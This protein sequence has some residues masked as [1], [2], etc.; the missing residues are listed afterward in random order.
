MSELHRIFIAAEL[1]P[2]LQQSIVETERQLEEAGAKLRWTKPANLHFTLRFLGEI[3]L[4]QVA[5]AKLATRE[6]AAAIQPFS[7]TLATL[8]AFPSLQRPQVVWVG[9][10]EG[11]ESL[12]T[13]A[14]RLDEQ[15][16]RYRFPRERRQFQPHLTLA[17]IR[18]ARAWGDLV[19]GL[20]QF[21][22]VSVGTQQIETL[23]VME[24]QLTPQGSSYTRVEE[25]RLGTYEK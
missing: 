3:P 16:V 5:K 19:R 14:A 13:L 2:A 23:V 18:D 20:T 4:A 17:R 10:A 7:I 8:G 11:R 21:K 1:A 22:D 9:V 6:A 15:L 24:S 25:V 12:Q